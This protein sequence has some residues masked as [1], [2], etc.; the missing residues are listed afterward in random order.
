MS[1]SIELVD[2]FPKI[3]ADIYKS[4]AIELNKRM[5]VAVALYDISVVITSSSVQ[6]SQAP[7]AT[8]RADVSEFTL[9]E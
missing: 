5:L 2:S 3:K 6:I 1:I 4:L 8:D 9:I 7:K